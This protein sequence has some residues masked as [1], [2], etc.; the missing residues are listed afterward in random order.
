MTLAPLLVEEIEVADAW[1]SDT[2]Y[3]AGRRAVVV[4]VTDL[5]LSGV[6]V[7]LDM[8]VMILTRR[9]G[10]GWL[11]ALPVGYNASPA[12][13]SRQILEFNPLVVAFDTPFVVLDESRVLLTLGNNNFESTADVT[14][15]DPL[16]PP[17]SADF[18]AGANGNGV[19]FNRFSFV[20]NDPGVPNSPLSVSVIDDPDVEDGYLVSVSLAT[21]AD[22]LVTTTLTDL[23]SYVPAATNALFGAGGQG[24][25]LSPL[26]DGIAVVPFTGGS[27]GDPPPPPVS[28]TVTVR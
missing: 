24:T 27:V 4:S 16:T 10:E 26:T 12:P 5:I 14:I 3:T 25:P 1:V 20:G 11:A 9:S 22:G 15:L 7:P 13:P 23:R 17:D 8:W 2:L 6:D 18:G 19:F 28:L 21:D